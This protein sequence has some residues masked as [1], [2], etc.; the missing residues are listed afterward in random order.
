M[1]P[2]RIHHHSH[3]AD[4]PLEPVRGSG[5]YHPDSSHP[6]R[7]ASAVRTPRLDVLL[8]AVF[9]RPLFDPRRALRTS[10]LA[11]E[12]DAA[13]HLASG[14]ILVATPEVDVLEGGYIHNWTVV[15]RFPSEEA[16]RSWYD[17][18]EY[19]AVIPNRH[20][21]SDTETAIMLLAPQFQPPE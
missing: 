11:A 1:I 8:L 12:E 14:E 9:L 15:V 2:G 17:S 18:P 21:E 5:R 19:Q 7:E 16:A 4:F 3:V 10:G 13:C 20:A 6:L